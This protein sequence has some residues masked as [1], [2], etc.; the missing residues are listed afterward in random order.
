MSHTARALR[1][2]NGNGLAGGKL[3]HDGVADVA[4]KVM[5]KYEPTNGDDVRSGRGSGQ[6]GKWEYVKEEERRT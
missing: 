1:R 2:R 3:L 6:G 5:R 4:A